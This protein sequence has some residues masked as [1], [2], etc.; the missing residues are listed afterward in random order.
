M[1]F[2]IC[3]A[4]RSLGTKHTNYKVTEGETLAKC[5]LA[6]LGPAMTD[7]KR[8]RAKQQE[9]EEDTEKQKEEQDTEKKEEHTV[10]EKLSSISCMFEFHKLSP[11][12]LLYEDLF[13]T[14][15]STH[16]NGAYNYVFGGLLLVLYLSCSFAR[17]QHV[18]MVIPHSSVRH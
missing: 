9:E 10:P 17:V 3:A 18:C 5:D 14:A 15:S 2:Y 8:A 4:R 13:E 11:E 1:F 6:D 16:V 7:V 12:E